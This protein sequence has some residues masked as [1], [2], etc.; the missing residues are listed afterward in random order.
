MKL[1]A[2]YGADGRSV[3]IPEAGETRVMNTFSGIL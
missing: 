1:E 3:G 2:I